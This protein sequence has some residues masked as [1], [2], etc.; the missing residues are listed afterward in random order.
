MKTSRALPAL[1]GALFVVTMGARAQAY[2]YGGYGTGYTGKKVHVP[3][4][5]RQPDKQFLHVSA[6][7]YYAEIASNFFNWGLHGQGTLVVAPAFELQGSAWLNLPGSGTTLVRGEGSVFLAIPWL[8]DARWVLSSGQVA[9]PVGW[10]TQ[11]EYV[12]IRDGARK[13]FGLEAGASVDRHGS[14]QAWHADVPQPR[15]DQF[16]DEHT[17]V[18]SLAGFGGIKWVH[19]SRATRL[20]RLAFYV[21]VIRAFSQSV[22]VTIPQGRVASRLAP[23]GGRLGTDFSIREV[24]FKI[25]LA[26]LPSVQFPDMSAFFAIGWK[27]DVQ[28]WLGL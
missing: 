19:Q 11:E 16:D 25:E 26:A 24:F 17:P 5:I 15:P 14:K 12:V 1:S 6:S 10:M 21:H 4:E 8:S 23:W 13:R 22:D 3:E 20:S 7:L 18:T 27:P 28:S 9:G 2:D